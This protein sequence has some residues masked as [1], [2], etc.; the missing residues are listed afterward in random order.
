MELSLILKDSCLQ[1]LELGIVQEFLE[2]KSH[3]RDI[4]KLYDKK[5]LLPIGYQQIDNLV[6]K[7]REYLRD[8]KDGNSEADCSNTV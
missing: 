8:N 5:I 1:K 6:E 2:F 3:F 4:S 7:F